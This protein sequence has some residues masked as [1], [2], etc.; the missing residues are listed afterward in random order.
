MK[1]S[2]PQV[3][4]CWDNPTDKLSREMKRQ[5]KKW[6]GGTGI[7]IKNG[8]S[9]TNCPHLSVP[10]MERNSLLVLRVADAQRQTRQV[11]CHVFRCK[12]NTGMP[13]L[14]NLQWSILSFP[15]K[16][17]KQSHCEL[18]EMDASR[19]QGFP[20]QHHQLQRIV[21]LRLSV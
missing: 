7:P 4:F 15:N 1:S 9:L 20:H 6:Q 16:D 8:N 10:V 11:I 5:F 12:S 3:Q 2:K 18:N 19:D 21:L 17:R 13:S 14:A